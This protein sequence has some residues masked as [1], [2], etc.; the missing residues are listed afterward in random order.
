MFQNEGLKF[1][2]CVLGEF[3]GGFSHIS[4]AASESACSN[5]LIIPLHAYIFIFAFDMRP[6]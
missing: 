1:K 5:S 6:S 3:M 4:N 2:T